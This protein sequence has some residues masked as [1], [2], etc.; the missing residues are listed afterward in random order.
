MLSSVC[1]QAEVL[2][3][4][5]EWPTQPVGCLSGWDLGVPK[6]KKQQTDLY[7]KERKDAY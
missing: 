6:K 3:L 2:G 4:P 1:H 7:I 5:T